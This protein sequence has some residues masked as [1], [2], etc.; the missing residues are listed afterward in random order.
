[1]AANNQRQHPK[2]SLIEEPNVPKKTRAA[3]DDP[4]TYGMHS[5]LSSPLLVPEI[6]VDFSD[7][8]ND[9]VKRVYRKIDC[10][11]TTKFP[12]GI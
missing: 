5:S 9:F 8:T 4:S 11:I 12:S 2:P 1:M 6:I 7:A 3:P 10:G